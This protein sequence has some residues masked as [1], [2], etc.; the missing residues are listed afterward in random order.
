ME[1]ATQEEFLEQQKLEARTRRSLAEVL[2]S[3]GQ[4]QIKGYAFSLETVLFEVGVARII[5]AGDIRALTLGSPEEKSRVLKHLPF[6]VEQSVNE[7]LCDFSMG[8]SIV[9]V[10]ARGIREKEG[11]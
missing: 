2:L 1:T 10:K 9:R 11:S 3:G 4:I 8:K 5:G 7:W 6:V